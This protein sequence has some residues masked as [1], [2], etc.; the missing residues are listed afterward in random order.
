MRRIF[1]FLVM[2]MGLVALG[3]SNPVASVTDSVIFAVTYSPN[4][5]DKGSVPEMQTKIHGTDLILADNSRG[6]ACTDYIFDGWNTEADG[7]GT[8]YAVGATYSADAKLALYAKWTDPQG[9]GLTHIVTPKARTV[10][11][12]GPTT[13]HDEAP[14]SFTSSYDGKAASYTWYMDD[15]ITSIGSLSSLLVTPTV[16]TH[17]YGTHILMLIVTDADGVSYAAYLHISVLN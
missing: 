5:A 15:L 6:L 1:G 11:I 17:K 8:T 3:C 13:L 9:T 14:V 10:T 7:S 16:A 12:N 2:A 4:N